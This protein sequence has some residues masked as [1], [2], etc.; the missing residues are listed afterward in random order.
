MRQDIKNVIIT[1][2]LIAATLISGSFL[3]RKKIDYEYALA[4]KQEQ[5]QSLIDEQQVA[6]DSLNKQLEVVTDTI[7]P[8]EPT[9]AISDKPR[10]SAASAKS[11][12]VK[13]KQSTPVA[14]KPVATQPAPQV[15][16]SPASTTVTPKPPVVVK[17]TR[18]S[19]A[20]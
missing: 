18:K 11:A 15:I 8:I 9:S 16:K 17:T 12:V 5:L 10:T 4:A 19:R 14:S 1:F 13:P 20:S 2:G 3:Y 7:Q 6:L